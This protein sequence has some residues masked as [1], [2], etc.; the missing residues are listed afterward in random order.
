[1]I[2]ADEIDRVINALVDSMLPGE[3]PEQALNRRAR[4]EGLCPDCL[5]TVAVAHSDTGDEATS[6]LS[7]ILVGVAIANTKGA[8]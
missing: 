1:M 7:G 8:Q 2:H 5:V 3:D 6:F 4:A